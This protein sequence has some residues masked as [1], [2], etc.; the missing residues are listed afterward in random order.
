M[1]RTPTVQTIANL[2]LI[3]EKLKNIA[4]SK[5]RRLENVMP[6][7]VHVAATHLLAAEVAH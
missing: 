3:L 6:F 7:E 5:D 1:P 4:I 2:L